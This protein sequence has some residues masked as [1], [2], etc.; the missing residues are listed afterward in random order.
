MVQIIKAIFYLGPLIFGIGFL[1][2]L[3]SQTIQ[4]V[5]WAPPFGLTPLMI[6]LVVGG[7]LGGIAQYRGRWI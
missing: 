1:A 2:P 5:G 7:L 3:V 4:A 6:G